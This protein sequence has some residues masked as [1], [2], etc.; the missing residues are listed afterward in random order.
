MFG[1]SLFSDSIDQDLFQLQIDEIN[2]CFRK[3]EL[4]LAKATELSTDHTN[5]LLTILLKNNICTQEE[6]TE[7]CFI[8]RSISI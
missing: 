6:Y 3:M 7:I 5:A 1:S 8:Y 4:K 2:I